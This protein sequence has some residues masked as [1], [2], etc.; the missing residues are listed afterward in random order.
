MN[1]CI[2]MRK[3]KL[4]ETD[5]LKTLEIDER[6]CIVLEKKTG[7]SYEIKKSFGE[8][9]IVHYNV[10]EYHLQLLDIIAF[11][12]IAFSPLAIIHGLCL[13]CTTEAFIPTLNY[14]SLV[15]ALISLIFN[16]IMHELAHMLAMKCYGLP[17]SKIQIQKNKTNYKVF[18]KTS[19][20][21]LLPPYKRIIVF[22]AGLLVNFYFVYGSLLLGQILGIS[23][24]AITFPAIML[25][26]LNS[27]PGLNVKS[28]IYF[29]YNSA[30]E[31]YKPQ[32]R[33]KDK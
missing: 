17:C 16:V 28:D 2:K 31:L 25:I 13:S 19:A 9:H 21:Y 27:I 24:F 7:K 5:E 4:Y 32:E 15:F 30:K 33:R 23:V 20:V 18:F 11:P 14:L 6:L 22:S 26:I 29:I 12:L 1:I 3:Y 8:L 10:Q